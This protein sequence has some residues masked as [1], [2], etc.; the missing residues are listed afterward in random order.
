MNEI[1]FEEVRAAMFTDPSVKAVDGLRLVPGPA[2]GRA[3]VA[4]ITVAAPSA[5]L[6]VV[7]A[8]IAR[9]LFDQFGI[10]QA[11][12]SFNDPGP[13]PPRPTTAPLKKL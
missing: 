6:D 10:E 4:T 9:V 12:L 11:V 7:H 1:N 13:A 5:D 8:V 2:T 3:I